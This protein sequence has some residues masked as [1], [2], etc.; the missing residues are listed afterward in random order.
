LD[1]PTRGIDV[2]AKHEIYLLLWKM[3]RKG[4]AVIFVSSDI[5]ELLGVCHR[6]TVLSKGKIAGTLNRD[7]FS[8]EKVLSLAY[9]EYL[10]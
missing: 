2:N 10:K 6:I 3:A 1:E 9:Q 4:A 7:E 8:Q 5:P